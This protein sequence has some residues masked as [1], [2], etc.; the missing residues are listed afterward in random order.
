VQVV[1]LLVVECQRFLPAITLRTHQFFVDPAGPVA[2]IINL[3]PDPLC[4]FAGTVRKQGEAVVRLGWEIAFVA[5]AFG[6]RMGGHGIDSYL[7]VWSVSALPGLNHWARRI[8]DDLQPPYH[9]A[10]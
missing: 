3:L 7:A 4:P 6:G 2:E 1:L 8:Y 5:G 10:L 9:S